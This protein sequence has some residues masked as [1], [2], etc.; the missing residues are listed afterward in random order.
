MVRLANVKFCLSGIIGALDCTQIPIVSLP[1]DVQRAYQNRKGW[2]SLNVQAVVDG[3]YRFLNVDASWPGSCH[4]SRILRDS[5][6]WPAFEQQLIDGILLGDSGYPSRQ[7]LLTPYANLINAVQQRYN[8]AH[9]SGRVCV[10]QTFGQWKRVFRILQDK[11]RVPTAKA[12]QIVAAC[13]VL[14][15]L[16]KA[17]Q[18]ERPDNIAFHDNFNDLLENPQ[19]AFEQPI[20]QP[21]IGNENVIQFR[22]Q[23]ANN[24]FR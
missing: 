4:D 21:F 6:L 18:H 11:I 22:D 9:A 16:R 24:Y 23:Y 15:N 10:E 17:I 20:V 14:H 3:R 12:P 8:D 1:L 13:A 2:Y 5:A 19:E 7:W